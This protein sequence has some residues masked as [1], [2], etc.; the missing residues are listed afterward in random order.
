MMAGRSAARP[1]HRSTGTPRRDSRAVAATIPAALALLFGAQT[2]SCT[3]EP[4]DP[5]P[6][7]SLALQLATRQSCGIFSGL[8]YDTS[9]LAAVAVRVLDE[10]GTQIHT[11]CTALDSRPQEL[12]QIVLGEPLIDFARLSTTGVVRFEVR[13]L[14]D[15]T[16]DDEQTPVDPCEETA[17]SAR[18]LFWGRSA[19]VDLK[20]LDD[21]ESYVARVV[22]DCRDCTFGCGEET[23][24]GCQGF[25]PSCPAAL[26]SSFCMPN[27]GSCAKSCETDADCFEGARACVDGACDTTTVTGGL[28]SPCGEDTRCADGL[29]CVA[30]SADSPALCAPLCPDV[31]CPSG[32]SCTRLGNRLVVRP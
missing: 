2:P 10:T 1:R 27:V 26:P 28:C 21:K 31:V 25:G 23:C 17:L 22:V 4:P 18:W 9:C 3:S 20:S 6:A 12:R 24:F 8:D 11:E 5:R 19:P 13:G 7:V 15:V 16:S 29:A 14:H 32:T 30:R